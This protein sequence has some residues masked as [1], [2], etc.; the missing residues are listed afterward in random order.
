MHLATTLLMRFLG[1]IAQYP[2]DHGELSVEF[3]L[4]GS[5]A[6]QCNY[7]TKGDHHEHSVHLDLANIIKYLL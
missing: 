7:H 2:D 5:W 1:G 6:P 4:A 3:L